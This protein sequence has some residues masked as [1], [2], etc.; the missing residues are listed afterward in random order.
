MSKQERQAGRGRLRRA[1]RAWSRRTTAP[2]CCAC[3]GGRIT[4]APSSTS[5]TS[6]RWR[7]SPAT[8]RATSACR[9]K[10]RRP[11]SR[12]LR[13]EAAKLGV[14]I[15]VQVFGRVGLALS[16]R[17]YHARAHGRTKD[18]CQFVCNEDPDGMTLRTLEDKPFLTVNGI[19][20]MSHDYLNLIGELAE[21]QAMGVT[22][23]PPVAAQLRHGGGGGRSSATRSTAASSR[24]RRRPA[25]TRSSS[26]R[27]SP[28]ASITASPAIASAKPRHFDGRRPGKSRKIWPYG[29]PYV[30]SLSIRS[31]FPLILR[32]GVPIFTLCAK[33]FYPRCCSARSLRR[34]WPT[35]IRSPGLGP[36]HEFGK[37]PDRLRRQARD[38]LQRRSAHR[39]QGGVPAY[40]NK[41]VTESRDRAIASSTCSATAR[42]TTR[43]SDYTLRQVDADHIE[44]RRSQAGTLKLQR[45]E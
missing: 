2:R 12:A 40:R 38:H 37:R 42:S 13:A 39:Q 6:A 14:S 9:R 15:E 33:R 28:T 36:E 16:A 11:P 43:R 25:S 27:R 26:T 31:G 41:S 35:V 5:T 18:S 3:A 19:Q 29:D 21:L 34:R 32:A 4:S 23:L 7:C 24:P 45:C 30:R 44:M 8:A 10:C 17:C 20:T 1:K 22:P